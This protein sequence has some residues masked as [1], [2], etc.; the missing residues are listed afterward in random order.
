MSIKSKKVHEIQ[1]PHSRRIGD[2]CGIHGKSKSVI[3]FDQSHLSIID[4]ISKKVNEDNNKIA[5]IKDFKIK[6]DP[7]YYDQIDYLSESIDNINYTKLL[8]TL[9]HLKIQINGCKAKL[10]ANLSK[11]L[12]FQKEINEAYNNL[13]NCINTTDFYNFVEL[14]DIPKD[15]LFIF[16]CQDKKLYAMD[17]RSMHTY[18]LE[19]QKEAKRYEKL[20]VYSNPYNRMEITRKTICQYRN[21]VNEL[22]NDNKM[23]VYPDEEHEPE[24]QLTFRVLEIF[25][26]I[27]GYGYVI[28]AS[29]FLKMNKI[30][31]LDFYL[32]LEDIWNQRLGLSLTVKRAI[33]PHNVNIFNRAEYLDLRG[34]EKLHLQS[35]MIEKISDMITCGIDR[36]NRILGIHYVLMALQE[37]CDIENHLPFNNLN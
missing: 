14:E 36:D 6:I 31:L 17:L 27:H 12:H 5:K 2:Y 16:K 8:K 19:L 32:S 30:D 13:T 20:V 29:W 9:R 22:S 26:I 3:R 4:N 37:I 25:N 24:D 10:I 21:R 35:I 11:E 18:F 33:V 1:C 23:V 28:D 15:Y 34:L 7:E